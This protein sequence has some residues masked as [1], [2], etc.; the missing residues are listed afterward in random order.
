MPPS[1]ASA[2]VS[3]INATRW[4]CASIASTTAVAANAATAPA[5]SACPA[6]APPPARMEQCSP[7]AGP[8]RQPG[9]AGLATNV[10]ARRFPRHS[11]AF[12]RAAPPAT[13][14]IAT[15]R[16]RRTHY[17]HFNSTLRSPSLRRNNSPAT[18]SR[19][20]RRTNHE[21]SRR[22]AP[23]DMRCPLARTTPP[24]PPQQQPPERTL[25]FSLGRSA[26]HAPS[27]RPASCARYRRRRNIIPAPAATNRHAPP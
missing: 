11:R 19:Q 5:G 15:A 20:P 2:T 6:E 3:R 18:P 4:A 24:T 14:P 22:G 23:H 21:S 9:S 10:S 26:R 13:T 8:R 25:I 12:A 16:S 17:G 27:L 7:L 1:A